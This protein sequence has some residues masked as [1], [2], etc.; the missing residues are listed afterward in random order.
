[1]REK[2]AMIIARKHGEEEPCRLCC[3]IAS[4]IHKEYMAWFRAEIE[5]LKPLSPEEIWDIELESHDVAKDIAQ[6][7]LTKTKEDLLKTLEGK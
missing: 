4:E 7:S 5:K 1:M 2:I 6:A 3:S